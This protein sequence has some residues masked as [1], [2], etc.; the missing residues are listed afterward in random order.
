MDSC[1]NI[2]AQ[3]GKKFYIDQSP[4]HYSTL[5]G[6]FQQGEHDIKTCCCVNRGH[7][8]TKAYTEKNGYIC[9]QEVRMVVECVN[10][11][12][13]DITGIYAD[14]VKTITVTAQGE[15]KVLTETESGLSGGR[16]PAGGKAVDQNAK[17]IT[18]STANSIKQSVD[19]TSYH[20][21]CRGY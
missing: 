6:E 12:N 16:V 4:L 3:T 15:R 9:G 8:K 10:D 13:R 19:G 20:T 7:L 11:C 21:T 1:N 18:V 2:V 5:H 17:R 14:F